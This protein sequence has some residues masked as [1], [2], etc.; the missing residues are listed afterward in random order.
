MS[1]LIRKRDNL[2]KEGEIE[3][4]EFDKNDRGKNVHMKPQVGFACIVDRTKITYTWM[5]S[6]ITEVISETEFKTQNSH[7]TIE[8]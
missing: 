1:R 3:Y 2:V 7:Y 4:I 6:T 5:T 8:K